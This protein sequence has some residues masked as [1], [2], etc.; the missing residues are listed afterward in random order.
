MFRYIKDKINK[1]RKGIPFNIFITN[2]IFQKI[3]RIDSD[4]KYSKNFTSRVMCPENIK[5]ENESKTVLRSFAVSG[6]CYFQACGGIELGENTIFA[7]GITIV[8]MEHDFHD[9]SIIGKEGRVKIGR[10]CW[11]GAKCTILTGV[12]L[13]NNTIV[14]AN[15]VVTKSFPEGNV[16]IGGIPAKIIRENK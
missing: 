6:N 8:S 9:V 4:C 16:V 13:G 1:K 15:S 2:A 14:G 5:I 7:H 3:L 11:L 10:N 12:E